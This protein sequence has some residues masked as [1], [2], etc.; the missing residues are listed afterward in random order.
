MAIAGVHLVHG[1]KEWSTAIDAL[2][3]GELILLLRKGGIADPARPFA[4]LCRQIALFP[5]HEHQAAHALKAEYPIKNWA[6]QADIILSGW[7][8]I[9]HG[10]TL[11]SLRTVQSL[12]PFHI[13]TADFIAERFNWRPQQPLQ[14]LC[15]RTYAFQ[16]PISLSNIPQY[17]GCRS[18]ITL[19]SPIP[20]DTSLPA[21]SDAEYLARLNA[22]EAALNL[23]LDLSLNDFKLGPS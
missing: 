3:T 17:G 16:Q 4:N 11:D 2:L 5:T 15:L 21:L 1:L 10:F 22:V 14:I 18:W 8:Q 19:E 7:A 12:L 13:W 23:H 9:T 6:S 20:T